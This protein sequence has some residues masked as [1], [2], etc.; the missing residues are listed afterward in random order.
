[1]GLRVGQPAHKWTDEQ[2]EVAIELYDDF[3]CYAEHVLK[4]KPKRKADGALVPFKFNTAQ[5]YIHFYLEKQKREIGKVRAYILKGRQQGCSTYIQGRYFHKTSMNYGIKAFI[6]T[7]SKAATG[8]LYSIAKRY[9]KNIEDPDIRPK[10]GISNAT[11]LMFDELD[12]GYAVSTA[13]S[14]ETGR[15]DTIDLL[16]C[17]EVP[18]WESASDH[19]TGLLQA[20]PD[21]EGSE[22]IFEST[23]N[24][25]GDPFHKG[26]ISAQAG[27]NGDYIAIFIPWYWQEEYRKPVPKGFEL[28]DEEAEY[29]ELY[30]SFPVFHGNGE[31]SF[32]KKKLNLEQ[33]VWM[34]DKIAEFGGDVAKFN[35]EYP[36]T[37]EKAFQFSAV[38]SHIKAEDVIKAMD[39][40]LYR[41]FGAI[42]A[43]F[44]PSFTGEGDRKAFI[45][46]QGANAWGLDYPDLKNH[47][48]QVNY[49]VEKLKAR[50]PYI[51]RLYVDFGGGGVSIVQD[52]HDLNDSYVE[53]VKVV[54]SANKDIDNLKNAN[55]RAGMSVRLKDHLICEDIPLAIDIDDKWREAFLIDMTAEG[56]TE[57]RN[58]K[59]LMEKK[60]K[61]K[62]RLGIS[63]D[64]SD[65]LK[66]T[67]A[68]AFVRHHVTGG[69]KDNAQ[70]SDCAA[71]FE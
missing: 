19:T 25:M 52:L 49:L 35:Q 37:P 22:I 4:I 27:L 36:P 13:G 59:F 43:G 16:H 26:F 62:D 56:S 2:L 32:I 20:V 33:I 21:V 1:M 6:Q 65:S 7:H 44:D 39:R 66:L 61:V 8:N 50:N 48:Q 41:S 53:R 64:G 47:R 12:S 60:E 69:D 38:K 28:T 9:L 45:F 70:D 63:P 14:K 31:I 10:V 5:R 57:D 18:F 55:L 34:R 15:S 17:S 46:R 11:T 54:N 30:D 71:W 58:N 42:K 29:I 3:E 40:P 68:D 23:A 67:Y 51:D 24:G